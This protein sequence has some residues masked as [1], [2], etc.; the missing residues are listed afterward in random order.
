MRK[1]LVPLVAL[2][3]AGFAEAPKSSRGRKSPDTNPYTRKGPLARL[4]TVGLSDPDGEWL[5]RSPSGKI[6]KDDKAHRGRKSRSPHHAG[7]GSAGAAGAGRARSKTPV[8][9]LSG[10]PAIHRRGDARPAS[11]RGVEAPAAPHK[12]TSSSS[13][14]RAGRAGRLQPTRLDFLNVDGF[15]ETAPLS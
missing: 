9:Q 3:F 1:M 13:P 11:P 15:S 14:F 12:R 10:E 8:G 2:L 4:K 6:R 7:G 5:R